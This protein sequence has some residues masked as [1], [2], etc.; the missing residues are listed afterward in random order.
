MEKETVILPPHLHGITFDQLWESTWLI[1]IF[2]Y[3]L[4]FL[5]VLLVFFSLAA[6][7]TQ[8][9]E[10][11]RSS[12]VGCR[13]LGLRNKSNL[14]DEHACHP[15][16]GSGDGS[17]RVK[18][19]FIYPIK[20]CRGVELDQSA[21][22][23]TGLQYDRQFC[24]AQL[25]S[26]FP[27][28]A[29]DSKEQRAAH[30]WRFVTQREL[31]LMSQV[32]TEMWVPDPSAPGY[33]PDLP[34]VRAGGAIVVTFPF[35]PDGW[36]RLLARLA[37][38]LRGGAP[39]RSFTIPFAPSAADVAARYAREPVT[40]WRESPAAINMSALLPPELR[41]AIGARNP[42]ALF[43]IDVPRTVLRTAPRKEALGWQPVTSF[44]DAFPL[45]VL[46]LA[47]VRDLSARQ[48]A[49]APRLNVRRFR[50]NVIV[51]GAP[52]YDEDEWTRIRVG[53]AEEQEEYHGAGRCVRCRLPN[54][55]PSS[56]VRHKAEPDRTLK[57]TRDVDAGAPGM[58]C[59]GVNMVPA[60]QEGV[61]RVGDAITV[62]ERGDIVYEKL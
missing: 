57:R 34:Y 17:F 30:R 44:A 42:L 2:V 29:T 9:A 51:E 12:P 38:T 10:L 22:V 55:E 40:I 19:L 4:A 49:D 53:V 15:S 43:R 31:P 26:P 58:G 8:R 3:S 1:W 48:P 59:L 7:L 27:A 61:I 52:P 16:S 33:A 32:R 56:G 41:Y 11:K 54:I 24:L 45:H 62:L 39:E 36:P 5:P 60:R 6:R 46:G 21:V 18:S 50:P 14:Q 13:R 20:S 35:R 28:S 47:S 37:A 23:S 25:V